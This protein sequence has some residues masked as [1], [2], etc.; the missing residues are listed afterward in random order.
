MNGYWSIYSITHEEHL[1]HLRI[2]LGI[3]RE[4]EKKLYAKLSKYEFQ[5]KEVQFLG[6]M[7]FV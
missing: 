1:E 4:K 7:I 6:H 3:L 2:V 5:M